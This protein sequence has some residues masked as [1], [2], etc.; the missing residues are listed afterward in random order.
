MIRTY[1]RRVFGFLAGN[2]LLAA[3]FSS[4]PIT[5][6]VAPE[7]HRLCSRVLDYI[8][9]VKLNSASSAKGP[10]AS[11]PNGKGPVKWHTDGPLLKPPTASE[12]AKNLDEMRC[13]KAK[14]PD[15]CVKA[16][17]GAYLPANH[18]Y[19]LLRSRMRK[20]IEQPAPSMS[21]PRMQSEARDVAAAETQI[22][23]NVC[24]KWIK[25][26]NFSA[27]KDWGTLV[28]RTYIRGLTEQVPGLVKDVQNL[29]QLLYFYQAQFAWLALSGHATSF[30][31]LGTTPKATP[32]AWCIQGGFNALKN[33]SSG[34]YL[35]FYSTLYP[36]LY[37]T[38]VLK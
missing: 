23:L 36:Y 20:V 28:A 14:D 38:S 21:S 25:Q 16:I 32:E 33:P 3:T 27:Q 31:E 12:R 13:Y 8:G 30:F 6:A 9:C 10:P 5:A 24:E 15:D 11:N 18:P 29:D 2:A 22:A 35:G 37:P 26:K 1:S 19:A 34:A 7:I 4:M 17:N